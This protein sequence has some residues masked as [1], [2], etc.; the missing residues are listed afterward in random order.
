MT[1][2]LSFQ[3]HGRVKARRPASLARAPPTTPLPPYC[4]VVVHPHDRNRRQKNPCTRAM[5]MHRESG[6]RSRETL[7]RRRKEGECCL[8]R[9]RL[10]TLGA[11]PAPA[12]TGFRITTLQVPR[13]EPSHFSMRALVIRIFTR[14]HPCTCQ[15][16]R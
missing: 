7:K 13:G 12:R 9:L 8:A 11:A 15:V 1:N 4:T 2:A 5:I 14:V 10:G 16:C 6:R 3:P